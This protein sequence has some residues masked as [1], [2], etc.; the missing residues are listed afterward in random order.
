M[1]LS[2]AFDTVNHSLL[3]AKL[4][5]YVFSRAYLKLMQNYSCNRQQWI[6]INGS[7]SDWTEVI[8]GVPQSSILGPL[9]FNMFLNDI[10][11]FIK[12]RNGPMTNAHAGFAKKMSH[13]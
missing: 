8:A 13:T 11:M 10:F 5:A 1:D 4:D 12:L 9:L 2:K 3:L 7:F 6:F